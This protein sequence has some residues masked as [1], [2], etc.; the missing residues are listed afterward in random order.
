MKK[1]NQASKRHH[2]V[3][4][5]YTSQWALTD[6]RLVEWSKP[7]REIKPIRRHPSET[8]YQDYLY[9]MSDLPDGFH[10]WFED[11]FFRTYDNYASLALRKLVNGQL[12]SMEYK[13]K[14]DWARFLVT[15]RFR[16]PDPISELKDAVRRIWGKRQGITQQEYESIRRPND[17]S[18]VEEYLTRIPREVHAGIHVNLLASGMDNERLI[19]HLMKMDW[20]VYLMYGGYSFLTSDWPVDFSLGSR[21]PYVSVPLSP[22]M[23]FVASEDR[24]LLDEVNRT[25]GFKVTSYVNNY[26]VKHARRFVYS[27]DHSQERY[28]RNNM[29]RSAAQP[30]FYPGLA[31]L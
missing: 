8:G 27:H 12:P 23:L 26:V 19:T 4:C 5:F 21:Q 24:K 18:T 10:Q 29:S 9:T 6:E 28:I 2:F 22:K 20:A 30:P 15:M 3:P 7:Y 14:Y 11:E 31:R 17:P 16:H 13:I 1:P 25:D